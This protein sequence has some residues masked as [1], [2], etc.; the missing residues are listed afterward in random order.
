MNSIDVIPQANWR[1]SSSSPLRPL[2]FLLALPILLGSFVD[3]TDDG[4]S[5]V[6]PY[7][8]W[9]LVHNSWSPVCLFLRGCCLGLKFHVLDFNHI[10]K[11]LLQSTVLRS[12]QCWR[13]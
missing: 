2:P 3:F 13:H 11:N 9:L 1:G 5:G 8:L 10:R 7:A 4:E 12:Q 6:A